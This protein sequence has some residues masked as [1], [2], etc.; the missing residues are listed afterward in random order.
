MKVEQCRGQAEH[1]PVPHRPGQ[2]G[3]LAEEVGVEAAV[4][5]VLVNKEE[6]SVLVESAYQSHK[7]PVS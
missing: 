2:G 6:F 5:H 7:V 3:L 1:D 4:G